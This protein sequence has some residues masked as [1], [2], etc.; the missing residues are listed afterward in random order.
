MRLFD[1][2]AGF[3]HEMSTFRPHSSLPTFLICYKYVIFGFGLELSID[4][5]RFKHLSF[6]VKTDQ[7]ATDLRALCPNYLRHALLDVL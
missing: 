2:F 7:V 6:C 5:G 3:W 1:V 4:F